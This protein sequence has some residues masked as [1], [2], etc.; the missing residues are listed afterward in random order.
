MFY[1]FC[2]DFYSQRQHQQQMTRTCRRSVY[3]WPAKIPTKLNE[4]NVFSLDKARTSESDRERAGEQ[5]QQ[6]WQWQSSSRGRG[7]AD[8]LRITATAENCL[9]SL[10]CCCCCCTTYILISISFLLFRRSF[11]VILY[12]VCLCYPCVCVRMCL[13]TCV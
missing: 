8:E 7:S 4:T 2:V 11:V 5:T 13:L 9:R 3:L 12:F 6:P 10:L 1:L